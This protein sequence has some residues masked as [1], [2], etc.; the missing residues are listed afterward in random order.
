MSMGK[1]EIEEQSVP[2][3]VIAVTA[4]H[5][6]VAENRYQALHNSPTFGKTD[7]IGTAIGTVYAHKN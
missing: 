1:A 6:A 7:S 2:E 4:A 3:P 5:R